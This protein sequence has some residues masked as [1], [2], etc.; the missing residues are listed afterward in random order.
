MNKLESLFPAQPNYRGS[1]Q[2]IY[3]EPIIGSGEKIAI[4]VTAIGKDKKYQVIQAIR[5]ELLDCLY[6][7]QAEKMQ[8][9]VDWI[10]NSANNEIKANSTLSK[11]SPPF[12]GVTLG[13]KKIAADE[14]IE[15]ILRQAIRISASLSTLALDAE[16]EEDEEQ[17]RKYSEHWTRSI[18]DEMRL[19]SPHFASHFNKKIKVSDTDILTSYGFLT[20]KYVSN[21]GLLVPSRLSASLNSMKAKLFD[22]ESLK[23]SQL[24]VKPDK[25]EM[26]IGMPSIDDPTLSN[27]AVDR[28]QDTV[29]MVSELA[30]SEDISLIQTKNAKQAA[31]HLMQSA[32]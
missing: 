24:L 5:P 18:A 2:T 9:M 26:I 22:L 31:E 20:E 27:K 3:L 32:A 8:T 6:G 13:K 21:F 29:K 12:D 1:W 15:G 30:H 14:N 28:L 4:A 10:V 23:K 7:S 19:I 16:R 11:W 25:Y 17:P